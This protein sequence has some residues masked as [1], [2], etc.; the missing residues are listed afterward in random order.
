[1]STLLAY[2]TQIIGGGGSSSSGGHTIVNASGTELAQEDKLKFAGSLKTTDDSTNGMTVVDDSPVVM[3]YE[4]W[5]ALTPEQQAAIPK[6][7]ITGWPDTTCTA[8]NVSFDNTGTGLSGTNVQSTLVEVNG[9]FSTL[10]ANNIS[11]GNGT[12]K[13]TLDGLVGSVITLEDQ[14]RFGLPSADQSLNNTTMTDVDGTWTI[15]SADY[16][17]ASN[18]ILTIKTSGM[19][20]IN[21]SAHGMVNPDSYIDVGAYVG[22]ITP[23]VGTC[24]GLSNVAIQGRTSGMDIRYLVANTTIKLQAYTSNINNIL[25]GSASSMHNWILITKLS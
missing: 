15:G 1:M 20:I 25:Y 13:D 2:G 19:Y 21:L 17:S 6:T 8:V 11:Y 24:T 18:N 7:L 12:V 22:N 5:I 14:A 4:Q 23:V 3:T 10:S 9:K 16:Y